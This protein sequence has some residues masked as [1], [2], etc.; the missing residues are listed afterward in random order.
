MFS[1]IECTAWAHSMHRYFMY[2]RRS[3]DKHAKDSHRRTR[4]ATAALL[5]APL[6]FP[7]ILL[8][9]A[10]LRARHAGAA[11]QEATQSAADATARATKLESELQSQRMQLA[12][13]AR[14]SMLGE[15][16]GA[17]A[18]EL[19]QPLTAIF[20]NARAAQR[21]FASDAACPPELRHI[22]ESIVSDAHRAIETIQRLR[23]LF[24]KHAPR[25]ETLD[26]NELLEESLELVQTH[27]HA[28]GVQVIRRVHQGLVRIR[29]DSVQLLQVLVNLML[30]AC[31]AMKSTPPEHRALT[32]ETHVIGERGASI[33]VTDSGSGIAADAAGRLFEP[34]FTTKPKGTGFGLSIARAIISSHGGRID[35]FN[36][37]GRGAT[38]RIVFPDDTCAA[39]AIAAEGLDA[40]LE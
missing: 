5:A 39:I 18:H 23:S 3:I 16:S 12:F 20:Y 34:F 30:N 4:A 26:L 7:V 6:L 15:L 24:M 10:R 17:F 9:G 27:L 13:L 36:N 28:N 1:A 14:A 33:S 11:L 29:G 32:L 37:P 19:S 38:F 21:G 31:D 8:C 40:E 35:A 22:M 25:R 2:R